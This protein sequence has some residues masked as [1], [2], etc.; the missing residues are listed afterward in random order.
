ME[1]KLVTLATQSYYRSQILKERLEK[2][3]IEC[4]LKPPDIGETMPGEQLKVRIKEKDFGKALGIAE[5]INRELG[6][7]EIK[8]PE[9]NIEIKRILVPVGFM[10]YSINAAHYALNIADK[11]NADIHLFHSFYNPY[12]DATPLGDDLDY[13]LPL[14]QYITE[15]E[16]DAK[17]RLLK[18]VTGLRESIK[19][20]NIS[21][22]NIDYSLVSGSI[23]E[24]I[25]NINEEYEPDLIVVGTKGANKKNND[26]MGRVTTR[27]VE[28]VEVPVLAIPENTKI[29]S[30]QRVNVLYA[31]NFD[32]SDF[33]ALRRLM[34]LMAPFNPYVYCVHIE[35]EPG[36]PVLKAKMQRIKSYF[37][38]YY[39]EYNIECDIIQND[40]VLDGLQDFINQKNI[41]MISLT[42]HKKNIIIR[43]FRPNLTKKIFFHTNVPLM[44][45]HF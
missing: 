32:D 45:F 18:V 6:E 14:D 19:K 30:K 15:I 38:E 20:R 28:N 12:V 40:D 33:S 5:E 37:N 41:D 34:T 9:E 29:E 31:T 13:N 39:G 26:F 1:D 42:M 7:E 44:V 43:L 17:K 23:D 35:N 11:L 4:Y 21:G 8:I 36:N 24:Q 3:H 16:E 2:N 10:D 25:I 22:V 27:I